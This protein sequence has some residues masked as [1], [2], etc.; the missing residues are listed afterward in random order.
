MAL[1]A[2]ELQAAVKLAGRP[3]V[4]LEGQSAQQACAG[5]AAESFGLPLAIPFVPFTVRLGAVGSIARLR[6]LIGANPHDK[7]SGARESFSSG[8]VSE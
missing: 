2:R 3:G 1:E 7:E 4:L 6:L 5:S 8:R